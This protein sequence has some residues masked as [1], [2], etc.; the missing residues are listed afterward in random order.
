MRALVL[1]RRV[2]FFDVDAALRVDLRPFVF[3]A[4]VPFAAA[5]FLAPFE[6]VRRFLV[7]AGFFADRSAVSSQPPSADETDCRGFRAFTTRLGNRI[8]YDL[9]WLFASWVEYKNC[10]PLWDNRKY[11]AELQKQR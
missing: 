8:V 11:I 7:A 3:L 9:W 4:L 2:V 1:F 5:G 10:C 6:D